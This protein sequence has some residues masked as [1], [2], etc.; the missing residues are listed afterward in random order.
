MAV[1]LVTVGHENNR[2]AFVHLELADVA[3]PENDNF[4]GR[5][6]SSMCREV[7]TTISDRDVPAQE[8][9]RLYERMCVIPR[10]EDQKS[11]SRRNKFGEHIRRPPRGNSPQLL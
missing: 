5:W 11:L 3:V 4:V 8:L 6:K 10:A 1:L 9:G 2:I 7:G